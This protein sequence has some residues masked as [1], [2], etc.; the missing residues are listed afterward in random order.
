LQQ[1]LHLASRIAAFIEYGV[2]D[3]ATSRMLLKSSGKKRFGR[4]LS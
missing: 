2:I 1:R 4:G 3:G